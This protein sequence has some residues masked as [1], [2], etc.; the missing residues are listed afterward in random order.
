MIHRRHLPSE[1]EFARGD[2]KGV[3][4]AAQALLLR[5][6]VDGDWM[7]EAAGDFG[8]DLLKKGEHVFFFEVT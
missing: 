8:R 2:G 6:Y 4:A 7:R 5:L 3:S 1:G